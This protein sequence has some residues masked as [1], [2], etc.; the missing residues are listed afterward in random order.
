LRII[1][2]GGSIEFRPFHVTY[3]PLAHSI[4]EGNGLLIETRLAEYSTLATENRRNAG[5][6]IRPPTLSAIGDE[7]VLALRI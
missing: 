4:P 7:G 2:R 5:A 1:E 3:V 6:S